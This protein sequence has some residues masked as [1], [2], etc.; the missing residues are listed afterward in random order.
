M[1]QKPP[2]YPHMSSCANPIIQSH[3]RTTYGSH[4]LCWPIVWVDNKNDNIDYYTYEL[5]DYCDTNSIQ[6]NKPISKS[7]RI[8]HFVDYTSKPRVIVPPNLRLIPS[9]DAKY[10]C[11]YDYII[12]QSEHYTIDLD[13]VWKKSNSWI[14]LE[15]TT[16]WVQFNNR[17]VA[18]DKV[19]KMN[20]RPTWQGSRGS[21]AMLKQVEA[22]KDLGINRFIMACV[23]TIDKVSNNLNTAGNA[24]WF[25]LDENQIKN[26]ASGTIPSN[27]TF[28]T[29]GQFLNSL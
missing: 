15:L 5:T 28:G 11:S 12:K 21:T 20:R 22:A 2:K 23:N 1:S 3:L 25:D 27:A 9:I 13:Y 6:G 18:E 4:N 17:N 16:F 8:N 7:G 26:I 14:A 19:S 10:E 24:Y 29:F